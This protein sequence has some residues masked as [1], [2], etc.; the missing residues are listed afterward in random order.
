[1][2]VGTGNKKPRAATSNVC[3]RVE[4]TREVR[5]DHKRSFFCQGTRAGAEEI[6]FGNRWGEHQAPLELQHRV[7][8][9]GRVRWSQLV[10]GVV[11]YL[12][13][14][15]AT[16]TLNK[17]A[18]VWNSACTPNFSRRRRV[19]HVCGPAQQNTNGVF[20]HS[21]CCD[22]NIN[23]RTM[24][25]IQLH[26]HKKRASLEHTSSQHHTRRELCTHIQLHTFR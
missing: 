16:P 17:I 7:L 1:M 20:K 22:S 23:I 24:I 12:P 15:G 18:H 4:W 9:I 6:E 11:W 13:P 26:S 21:S 5:M 2:C 19:M 3:G 10:D 25:C 8:W 14:P